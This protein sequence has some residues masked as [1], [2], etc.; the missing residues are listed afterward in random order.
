VVLAVCNCSLELLSKHSSG[1]FFVMVMFSGL[2]SLL[3]LVI[4]V[5]LNS[6]LCE[7]PTYRLTL[8]VSVASVPTPCFNR[9]GFLCEL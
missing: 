4:A 1:D 5:Y 2:S 3:E 8:L 7:Y 9:V 6:G